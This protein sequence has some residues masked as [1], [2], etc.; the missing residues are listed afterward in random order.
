MLVQWHGTIKSPA[1]LMQSAALITLYHLTQILI[2]RSLI[3]LP[4]PHSPQ[5]NSLKILV[6]SSPVSL[7]TDPAINRCIEAAL[8]CARIVEVQ[9]QLGVNSFYIPGIINVSY[10][11]VGILSISAW[12]LKMQEKEFD[13]ASITDLKPPLASRIEECAANA[14]TFL[15]VLEVVKDHWEIAEVLL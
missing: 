15:R 9:L 2:W 5:K 3:S 10:I 1:F 11:C 8:A 13:N 6:G 12:N 4:H 14:K 7:V